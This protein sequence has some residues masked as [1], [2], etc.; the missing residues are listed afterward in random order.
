M[1][2][3]NNLICTSLL[4][5][6]SVQASANLS[7]NNE[8][9]ALHFVS[10]KKSSIAEVHH[11]SELAGKFDDQS[12]EVSIEI[13]LASVETLIPIRNERMQALLFETELYPKAVISAKVDVS[14][15]NKLAVGEIYH[16]KQNFKLNLH[17]INNAMDAVVAI[18]KLKN[19]KFNVTSV[20]PVIVQA[21]NFELLNGINS[22]KNIANLPSITTQVPVTFNLVF[23]SK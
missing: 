18:T 11:F 15:I 14:K 2:K 1:N 6:F 4:M 5:L 3:L 21:A 8:Q 20:K 13:N 10:V 7:L 9:S 17:G 23:E 12:G 19:G 16:T 22:L